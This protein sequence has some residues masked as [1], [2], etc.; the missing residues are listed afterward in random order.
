MGTDAPPAGSYL[1]GELGWKERRIRI[2]ITEES[3]T[4]LSCEPAHFPSHWQGGECCE[5]G[6]S[7]GASWSGSALSLLRPGFNPVSRN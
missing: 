2:R 4:S 6:R 7:R 3:P 1:E 5:K